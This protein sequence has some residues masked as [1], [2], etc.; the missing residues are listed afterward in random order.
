M[1]NKT[2]VCLNQ[3]AAGATELNYRFAANYPFECDHKVP[4]EINEPPGEFKSFK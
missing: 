4:I 1:P 2:R 3:L